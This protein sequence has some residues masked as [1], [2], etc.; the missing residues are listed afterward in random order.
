MRITADRFSFHHL[1]ESHGWVG[2]TPFQWDR[3]IGLLA[4][5]LRL[6]D[7]R[8]IDIRV[9]ARE[10]GRRAAVCISTP[11]SPGLSRED[12][13]HLKKAVKRM[14]RLGEDLSGFRQLCLGDRMLGFVARIGGGAML[15]C[16]TAFEDLVKTICTT[17]CDW[18]NTKKMCAS[19]C[20]LDGGNFPD[21]ET[22]LR[23]SVRQLSR[24]SPLG[25]RARTV[26]AAARLYADERLPLDAWAAAGDYQSIRESLLKIWG[27]G[28]YCANHMLVLLGCYEHIPVD[29]EVLKYLREVHHEGR[30]VGEPEAVSPYERYGKWRY[31]AYKFARMGRRMN[32]IDK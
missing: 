2:L 14:L 22:I 4:R 25:Y 9:R 1:V 11:G 10:E 18:R 23:H 3:E 7:G 19:L 12:Q 28:P 6:P 15:R 5:P 21:P 20:A 31:L 8:N 16:P 13:R 17:N 29:S 27:V 32:Y 26:R 30:P 24:K